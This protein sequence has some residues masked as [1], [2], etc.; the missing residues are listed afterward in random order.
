MWAGRHDRR[1]GGWQEHGRWLTLG[2]IIRE[3]L[4]DCFLEQHELEGQ[5]MHGGGGG[6]K[7]LLRLNSIISS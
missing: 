7:H 4:L 6:A 3:H 1:G 5:G 2:I